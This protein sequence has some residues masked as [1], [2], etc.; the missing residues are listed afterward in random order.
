MISMT[1][2]AFVEKKIAS[3][4]ISVELKSVN[5]RFLDISI[6]LPQFLQALEF[7]VRNE[8]AKK[9]ARGKVDVTIRLVDE[10]E[11]FLVRVN[12]S[13][14]K[15]YAISFLELAKMLG[16]KNEVPLSLLA[17]AEG[18]LQVEKNT[19]PFSFWE[20]IREVLDEAI[21]KFSEF[22]KAEGKN[23]FCDIQK[24]L[25][26]LETCAKFF[27]DWKSEL[28]KKLKENFSTKFFEVLKTNIDEKLLASEMALLLVK[29]TINEEVVRLQS[30][31]QGLKNEIKKEHAI[32]KKIDFFCQE[33]NREINTIASKNQLRELDE[34]IIEAKTA[35]ENIREQARNVE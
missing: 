22:R 7:E 5:A 11:N 30:H 12:H 24:N 23:L 29:Y 31:L 13:L 25:E 33:I 21:F 34:K 19:D 1:G 6:S 9:I 16:N 10:N 27:S 4:T 26:I 18:V 3:Q 35:L 8:I 15:S 28:E 20:N 2:Y 17:N 32:G 14:A